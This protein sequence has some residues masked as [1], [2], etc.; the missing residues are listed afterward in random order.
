MAELN[1]AEL[2]MAELNM[3]EL[4]MAELRMPIGQRRRSPNRKELAPAAWSS[5]TFHLGTKSR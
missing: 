1:M 2:N 5:A 4:T 3:A